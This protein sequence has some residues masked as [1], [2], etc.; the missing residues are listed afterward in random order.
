M[1]KDKDSFL[2]ALQREILRHNFNTF[3]D[4]PPSL[5]E[6]TATWNKFCNY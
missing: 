3:V 6:S 5:T 4:N 1:E 2:T